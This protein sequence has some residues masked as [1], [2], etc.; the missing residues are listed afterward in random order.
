MCRTGSDD[1]AASYGIP[2]ALFAL[3]ACTP[4]LS[5]SSIRR[6]ARVRASSSGRDSFET[7]GCGADED[8][9]ASKAGN[10][11]PEEEL[12]DGLAGTSCGRPSERSV[13]ELGVWRLLVLC[14]CR[15]AAG[16]K[17]RSDAACVLDACTRGDCAKLPILLLALLLLLL[18]L[19][20]PACCSTLLRPA[21]LP[22]ATAPTL[23]LGVRAHT[24]R[25]DMP[26]MRECD[27]MERT[28]KCALVQKEG[29]I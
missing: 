8:G 29:Q 28:R 3:C 23:L 7:E 24:D 22:T 16:C 13:P 18:L 2:A 1:G 20:T 5:S 6:S 11:G 19:R 26:L 17:D 14:S 15:P 25:T 27:C 9:A 4:V 10:D 12:V 21:W